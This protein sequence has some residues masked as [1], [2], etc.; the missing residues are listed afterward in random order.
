MTA[1][2]G[3]MTR[4]LCILA[5][6]GTL[7]AGG[8]SLEAQGSTTATVAGSVV[9]DE[10]V[11]LTGGD[12]VV[13]NRSSGVVAHGMTR[14]GRYEVPNLEI[15]GPYLI[16]VRAIGFRPSGR[17]SVFLRL[18][19]RL[20]LDFRLERAAT[21]L[22]AT[23]VN[24]QPALAGSPSGF[25]LVT[26][27]SDSLLR[28]LPTRNRNLYDFVQLSPYVSTAVRG[29]SGGGTNFRYNSF[30]IDGAG[31]TALF[32]RNPAGDPKSIPI[33]A[34]RE[35]HV[36]MSPYDVSQGNFA[37][38]LV[39][40][41]TQSGTNTF[42]GS[43]YVYARNERL[44]R[45]VPLLRDSPYEQVQ[46]GLSLGGPIVHDRA[47]FFVAAELQHLAAPVSGPYVGQLAKSAVPVPAD[48]TDVRR[49]VDLLRTRGID[50]GSTGPMHNESPLT[51][52]FARIDVA[53]PRWRSRLVLSHNY[54]EGEFESFTRNVDAPVFPLGS[55]SSHQIVTTNVTLAQFFTRFDWG[56]NELTVQRYS[57]R[58]ADNPAVRAPLVSVA[59][60][61]SGA[62]GV[63]LLEAGSAEGAQNRDDRQRDVEIDD[64]LSISIGTAHRL[65]VGASA[66]LHRV[67]RLLV[68]GSY[69][70]WTFS[71]LDSLAV[72]QAATYHVAKD[73]GGGYSSFTGAQY[74]V[75]AAD[76]W[77]VT[78]HL[79]LMAGLRVDLPVLHGNP[80]YSPAVDSLFGLRTDVVP[81]GG[82]ALSPRLG[83]AWETADERNRV[84]GGLGIFTSRAPLVWWLDAF[85]NYGEGVRALSCG[86]R[87]TD[88]GPAPAF[89]P[90]YMNPPGSCANGLGFRT[91]RGG[92]V[93][94]L[95]PGLRYPRVLRTSLA[96]DRQL[97]LGIVAS[98]EGIY[99]W[100]ASDFLF[101]NRALRGPVATDRFGRVLYGAIDSTGAATPN[102]IS[103]RYP[104]VFELVNQSRNHS[105][106]LAFQLE[107]RWSSGV[108]AR[109]AYTYSHVRD[110]QTPLNPLFDDNWQRGRAL[111]GLQDAL[112]PG[113]SAFDQPH[114][115]VAVATYSAPWSKLRS[116][117]SLY[118]V[119]GSGIPFTY[120]AAQGSPSTGDLNADG[121]AL[122]DPVYVP[123]TALDSNE[124]RFAGTPGEVAAQQQAFEHF[125]DT[126]PCL[127]SQR[128]RIM[129][130]NSC[131]SPWVHT[132]N[133][134]VRQE[135]PNPGGHTLAL[136]VEVFNLLN[137][138]HKSWGLAK[139]PSTALLEQVGQTAGS[140]AQSQPVFRFRPGFAPFSSDNLDSY[141][142]LQLAV[143]YSF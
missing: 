115:V 75:Y 77:Q 10:Q 68:F 63:T 7:V 85:G 34:V 104:A 131:R 112:G 11:P 72:G 38:V 107:K 62:S 132:L 36:V 121:T 141:F 105:Y 57:Q 26:V 47:H 50:A 64:N 42:H 59:V 70:A 86:P 122:N 35:Y 30:L 113:V 69:G 48:T 120:T 96:Y 136:E 9:T 125:I 134:A 89:D 118:Y 97:P 135:L 44:A 116:S 117:L 54:A 84:R 28:R 55:L 81:S 1:R 13:I 32:G 15:G 3:R 139:L 66:E 92:P 142:Q 127:R 19:E 93:N 108:E 126:T 5:L 102:L 87:L 103:N 49:F 129:A 78:D 109:L 14:R 74:G 12:I 65:T 51:N 138:V 21:T 114:R 124:I 82:V 17:D 67:S 95:D 79:V 24:A 23:V 33:D 80:P 8:V 110:V 123:R 83:F 20:E 76:R 91:N 130:R 61:R 101:L 99:S 22:E 143:R 37:G 100:G 111:S 45:H 128:G 140:P 88:V 106:D 53:L 98:V 16:I 29:I 43:T 31:A 46:Y 73:F 6:T 58:N 4:M 90:H 25:G 2:L 41:V 133:A 39:N 56:A 52:L 119:G 71:S 94:V 137:L 27:I 40:A 60:P 18:G